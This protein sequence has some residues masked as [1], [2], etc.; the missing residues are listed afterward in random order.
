MLGPIAAWR[1]SSNFVNEH[2]WP[3]DV[4]H[5]GRTGLEHLAPTVANSVRIPL[6]SIFRRFSGAAIYKFCID[7]LDSDM[8]LQ[9]QLK[10]ST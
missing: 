9:R 3:L 5:G 1:Y 10:D 4:F 8:C 6:P 7:A 2:V